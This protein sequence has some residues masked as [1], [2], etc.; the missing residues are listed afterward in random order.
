MSFYTSHP[1]LIPIPLVLFAHEN[2]TIWEPSAS[3][4][5][6][7]HRQTIQE[8]RLGMQTTTILGISFDLFQRGDT[9]ALEALRLSA[10]SE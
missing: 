3:I 5:M 6:L 1:A 4:E 10:G 7:L 8:Q 2:P 9:Q